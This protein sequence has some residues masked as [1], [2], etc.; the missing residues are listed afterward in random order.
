MYY[1]LNP[2]EM[3]DLETEM[4]SSDTLATLEVEYTNHKIEM[5]ELKTE[6]M[7]KEKRLSFFKAV[8]VVLIVAFGV[9]LGLT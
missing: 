3:E 7:K 8:V 2:I 6:L 1:I 9:V 5:E 4:R